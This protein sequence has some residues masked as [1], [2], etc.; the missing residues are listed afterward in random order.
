MNK[1]FELVPM[2]VNVTND[3]ATKKKSP[4]LKFLKY[5]IVG[6][7][8][9]LAFVILFTVGAEK[10]NPAV[11]TIMQKMG[12][13][14]QIVANSS[15]VAHAW[16]YAW[17]NPY[18]SNGANNENYVAST[19]SFSW[20]VQNQANTLRPT[21]NHS[22]WNWG[23]REK[24]GSGYS[25]ADNGQIS[26]N[27]GNAFNVQTIF[28]VDI[29]IDD[30]A[31]AAIANGQ[32]TTCSVKLAVSG[33][34]T[35]NAYDYGMLYGTFFMCASYEGESSAAWNKMGANNVTATGDKFDCKLNSSGGVNTLANY[36]SGS[37]LSLT[38][39]SQMKKIR[40]GLYYNMNKTERAWWYVSDAECF[41]PPPTISTNFTTDSYKNAKLSFSVNGAGGHIYPA[42]ANT[43]GK[44]ST[45]DNLD[46]WSATD[47]KTY[48]K[49]SF[50]SANL[51]GGVDIGNVIAKPDPGYYFSGWKIVSGGLS[52]SHDKRS[53]TLNIIDGAYLKGNTET[54]ITAYFR[55]LDIVDVD[56]EW[57]YLQLLKSDGTLELDTNGNPTL[58]RQG[59]S[60][61]VPSANSDTGTSASFVL[62]GGV[63]SD[64]GSTFSSSHGMYQSADGGKTYKDNLKP[65]NAGQ[66]RLIV[67]VFVSGTETSTSKV[68]GYYITTFE[69]KAVNVTNNPDNNHTVTTSADIEKRAYSG[70]AYTPVPTYVDIVVNGRPY[71][72]LNSTDYT[73]NAYANNVNV[74]RDPLG[75]AINGAYFTFGAKGNFTG[76]NDVKFGI[77]HLDISNFTYESAMATE[78]QQ[79]YGV[80]YNGYEQRPGTG[81]QLHQYGVIAIRITG[82]VYQ[83]GDLNAGKETKTF[84]I[85]I[86]TATNAS[87]YN[88]ALSTYKA[89]GG[90]YYI[91]DYESFVDKN[92]N[93]AYDSGEEF[94]DL[95]GNG[96]YDTGAVNTNKEYSSLVMQDEGGNYLGDSYSYFYIKYLGNILIPDLVYENNV[97]VCTY[98][99]NSSTNEENCAY[100]SILMAQESSNMKGELKAFFNIAPLDLNNLPDGSSVTLIPQ[101]L[102]HVYTSES[103]TPIPDVVQI[104]VS[105]LYPYLYSAGDNTYS[106][107]ETLPIT[108]SIARE[109]AISA[110]L[111][112]E[113]AIDVSKTGVGGVHSFN[114]WNAYYN[115]TLPSHFIYENN[116]T[117]SDSAKISF[118]LSAGG[119][120]IGNVSTLFS[121]TPRSFEEIATGLGSGTNQ[122]VCRIMT[123]GAN[124]VVTYVGKDI[125]VTTTSQ[126]I[127]YPLPGTIT[128][129]VLEEGVDFEFSFS[130]NTQVTQYAIMTVTGKGNYQGTISAYYYIV[131]RDVSKI[132]NLIVPLEDQT[133]T[134]SVINPTPDTI[135]IVVDGENV[136]LRRG[137]D[138]NK[139]DAHGENQFVYASDADQKANNYITIDFTGY[140]KDSPNKGTGGNYYGKG[141]VAYFTIV[142]KN[143]D[144][145]DVETYASWKNNQSVATYNGESIKDLPLETEKDTIKGSTTTNTLYVW[146]TVANAN[147]PLAKDSD[148]VVVGWGEN[149][150]AGD[151]SGELYVE[152]LGNYTGRVTITFKIY[153]RNFSP[154]EGYDPL[155]ISL[156]ATQFEYTGSMITPTGEIVK[157]TGLGEVKLVLGKDYEL[158]YG[159]DKVSQD[160][161][162]YNI[163]VLKGGKVTVVGIGNYAG[164][165][166]ATFA[167]TQKEQNVWLEN[168]YGNGYNEDI[169]ALESWANKASLKKE[170]NDGNIGVH[171]A[172]YE[173]NSVVAKTMT[174]VAYTDAIYPLRLV[175]IKAINISGSTSGVVSVSY[176][177]LEATEIDGKIYAKTTAKLTFS[178]NYGIVRIYAVQED[179]VIENNRLNTSTT[180]PDAKIGEGESAVIYQNR[181][182]YKGYTHTWGKD[183]VYSIYAKRQ[184][185]FGNGVP[186]YISK[187]YGNENFTIAPNLNSTATLQ[188][189]FGY[190]VKT[191]CSAETYV[192]TNL[193]GKYDA[194]ETFTDLN[195]N[196]AYDPYIVLVTGTGNTRTASVGIAGTAT[197]TVYHNGY[198][199]REYD[200][201]SGK[202]V[203][204]DYINAGDDEKAYLAFEDDISVTVKKRL[205]YISFE[206]L[207]VAYGETPEFKFT[208]TTESSNTNPTE[209]DPWTTLNY[210][211][212][213]DSIEDIIQGFKVAYDESYRDVN[214]DRGYELEVFQLDDAYV[215]KGSLYDNYDIRYKESFLKIRKKEVM[216]S[217]SMAGSSA[218]TITKVYGAK[219]PTST[220]YT[221]NYDGFV[222]GDTVSVLMEKDASFIAP[223]VNFDGGIVIVTNE[224][225]GTTITTQK[226]D[227]YT[228]VGGYVVALTNGSATSYVFKTVAV[229][230]N[231]IPAE[232][233]IKIGKTV[234]G[235][236]QEATD[237][238]A[239]EKDYDGSP[240]P[241][242]KENVSIQGLSLDHTLPIQNDKT[243]ITFTYGYGTNETSI[244]Q[245]YARTY[246]VK[247]TFYAADGDNYTTT[248]Q[249]FE[250]AIV[251][252][253]VPPVITLNKAEVE[254]SSGRPIDTKYVQ[255]VISRL[256]GG[257]EVGN[258][259]PN[260]LLFEINPEEGYEPNYDKE[261]GIII[262]YDESKYTDTPPSEIGV[263]DMIV[264]YVAN[265]DDC[266]S[267]VTVY[268]E[269]VLEVA[270]GIATIN[271]TGGK[272]AHKYDG[273]GFGVN[274]Q[275]DFKITFTSQETGITQ[276]ISGGTINVEYSID[277]I[278]FTSDEPKDVGSYAIKVTYIPEEGAQIRGNTAT[279]TEVITIT[280]YDL[281]EGGIV[282]K[283]DGMSYGWHTVTYD[284]KGHAL[285]NSEIV[286]V[287]V[288]ADQ[289]NADRKPKGSISVIY[290]NEYG[291]EFTTP[292]GAG[293]YKARITYIANESGDNYYASMPVETA[294]V[295]QINPAGVRIEEILNNYNSPYTGNGVQM[296][297][298]YFYGVEI[299]PGE[300]DVPK[301]TLVYQYRKSGTQDAWSI[302]RPVNA[303]TYDVLVK[304]RAAEKDNYFNHTDNDGKIGIGVITIDPVKPNIIINPMVFDFGTNI[305]PY[306]D[307]L[308]NSVDNAFALLGA[309]ADVNGPSKDLIAPD[310]YHNAVAQIIVQYGTRYTNSSTNKIEYAWSTTP[311]T[312]S[313]KYSIKVIYQVL[314]SGS[315]NYSTTSVTKQDYL[316]INNIVPWFTL[317]S[318]EVD[319]A[320]TRM[321]AN[322]AKIFDSASYD[323]E[324]VKWV[325]GID[326][327][328]YN[329]YYGT[330]SYEYR[331]YGTETWSTLAPSE[332]GLYDVRVAYIENKQK[333]VFTSTTMIFEGA[334][335]I[336]QLVITVMPIYGQGNVYD[337]SYTDGNAIA[338]V[339]S[340]ERDGYKY[341]VYSNVGNL[342]KNE[343][344]DISSAEYVADN[345]YVYTIITDT[346]LLT[347][348]WLDY[349]TRVLTLVSGSFVDGNTTVEFNFG[350]LDDV[351]GKVA[352]TSGEG[353]NYV[354]DLDNEIVYLNDGIEYTLGVESGYF[355]TEID[356]EGRV[357]VVKIQ[358][359]SSN[360]IFTFDSIDGTNK[361]A[362]VN[363]TTLK[364]VDED[365]VVYD[366]RTSVGKITYPNDGTTASV[367]I[368]HSA[369]YQVGVDG[370]A[371]YKH[372]NGSAFL[373]DINTSVVERIAILKVETVSFE[374]YDLEGD[375]VTANLST[376]ELESIYANN[377]YVGTYD[378]SADLSAIINLKKKTVRIQTYW[379]LT[380]NGTRY[381]FIDING[382]EDRFTLSQLS[383]TNKKDEYLY[384]SPYGSDY[385]VDLSKMIIRSFAN[386]YKFDVSESRI[387]QEVDGVE[388]S[389]DVDVKE[390]TFNVLRNGKLYDK[391]T[392]YDADYEV[393]KTTLVANN[394][395]N[396]SMSLGAQ[397]AGSYEIGVGSLAIGAN[398]GITFVEGI[399]Y[400]VE[401]AKLQIE[402]TSNANTIYDGQSKYVDYEI[403]GLVNGESKNAL[404][405]SQEYEGD[406]I[407]VTDDGYRTRV[408]ITSVNYY[409]ANGLFDEEKGESVAYSTFYYVE[410]A[411]MAPIVFVRG[412]DIV[413][414]GLKHYLELKNVERGAKVTYSG[415]T[416][417]P[418][419]REPGIYSIIATVSKD[420]YVSQE[421]ELTL[422]ITKAKYEVNALEVPG[423]LTYGDPLPA[424]RCDSQLGT[425][426]L[427]PGQVLLPTVT[428]YTWTFTPHSQEFY[429]FYEGNAQG[430]NTIT[431]T[432]ELKVQ[433]AQ[434]HIQINGQLVQSETSPS[435]IV[436]VANGLS[437]NESDLVTIEYI[438]ADGT[439][440]AK[441]PT[442]AGKYTVQ[443][444]YAGDEYHAETVYTTILTIEEESNYDWLIILGSVLLGLTLMSTVFFLIR[445]KT[446]K[447]N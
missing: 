382:Y 84:T 320:G 383:A 155:S 52:S 142:P 107:K 408:S 280:P 283:L 299:A 98:L 204:L 321:E 392:L 100:F 241:M 232:V 143:L 161:L 29:Y 248:I 419:F 187:I 158:K 120:I 225:T 114:A 246:S 301:G 433:K 313:G 229:D 343:I 119:N 44:S 199:P 233:V 189:A 435:A 431:G 70:T 389:I 184:D 397:N 192:D 190:S 219:N 355:F 165:K 429:K 18:P 216:V 357:N 302:N 16:T 206:E 384:S 251:I 111:V 132:Q 341:M 53:T 365:G 205:L 352:F 194:G 128:S 394:K 61:V 94:T 236:F 188:N 209:S 306:Y 105:G 272:K 148:Y 179:D 223:T 170:A 102:S 438:A 54:K 377:A 210:G 222:F 24:S 245:S 432:I 203:A 200:S 259:K 295:M 275:A 118:N 399:T 103:I 360:N 173:I 131:A 201:N 167:I 342:D 50:D 437:H 277:G 224:S 197:I 366:V 273:K 281:A 268:F 296:P 83:A 228:G 348:A 23:V 66:Y 130:N 99:P 30:L 65:Y 34:G 2:E 381:S 151:D 123:T 11:D 90:H 439:R 42:V 166:T 426:T 231:V 380:L 326:E 63:Y 82:D 33:V 172:D 290:V 402:F 317:E 249:K 240:V 418:Y 87:A 375:I 93:G 339:Y 168:P 124:N 217:V 282:V 28:Y 116:V 169:L 74:T 17:T 292:V 69:I 134:G 25:I 57:I 76:Q 32:I 263:Y 212:R 256:P 270:T 45:D 73:I 79:N 39:N 3:T 244:A 441:M 315:S 208:Y 253:K 20:R 60:V 363:Y 146:D 149:I 138:Y 332:V 284:A 347:D 15:P 294:V 257:K 160:G 147:A 185:S 254:Y 239:I 38:L 7:A 427:D 37:N 215:T 226:I 58:V 406:N 385:Y 425:I 260:K 150:N 247:V 193:N 115:G 95:N 72:M 395:W 274:A 174:V 416:T 269:D 46:T 328:D 10:I 56:R 354:I 171:Y 331:K 409:L 49:V 334:L 218:N 230:L 80:V 202:Y 414:D 163:D 271:Y 333:D 195:G 327:L 261:T 77:D 372:A 345:G 144:S 48:T 181:G 396:G 6:I 101:T 109:E 413:Y 316:T 21:T 376:S 390:F 305:A 177:K 125:P 325:E 211:T 430:G 285:S 370:K 59:P 298:V 405:I 112:Y 351:E 117:V 264:I 110:G 368:D 307:V 129:E 322:V 196:G 323:N 242:T 43:F 19:S 424:L 410:P 346:G 162:D 183:N 81:D 446:K 26:C 47:G 344:I 358:N 133:Y 14:E 287:P 243:R 297:P 207:T 121:I 267:D 71:R 36:D 338:Y 55:K 213:E 8:V 340:Y 303:G 108:Y 417:A 398:Y 359:V 64:T 12:M 443:V 374:Y 220:D 276:T 62:T 88:D 27:T 258:P 41:A 136:T 378:I 4:A 442:T 278:T 237:G 447:I 180:N 436:G 400:F 178:N 97:D 40:F 314:Q 22:G 175:K 288:P 135:T 369:Y 350:D 421:V 310:Q 67:G 235:E 444:T 335:N 31:R 311:P 289:S 139:A 353:K 156:S 367:L 250:G 319:Y 68:L 440:Y 415:S 9:F 152:G 191:D 337:G 265:A 308:D 157:D 266:Y 89:S 141:I 234:D 96:K 5:A 182:N 122:T 198:V 428:T 373:I 371:I 388:T 176:T 422:V 140:S 329:C 386:W 78:I 75:E 164:E 362:T 86:R 238:I 106:N 104:K 227:T 361:R 318:K 291:D 186:T 126:V 145:S 13:G 379:N 404:T 85:Y 113:D 137:V 403:F 127:A 312:T 255:P 300:Y 35:K 349:Y 356:G 336:N 407:N 1:Q 286:L 293:K 445:G 92:S 309:T 423:T 221:I 401:R 262:S 324:Y 51:Y 330:I 154:K 214:E 420:N 304:Y 391:T 387:F 412:E 252:N 411:V 393:E 153:P 159:D 91:Y 434:A 364:V 279:F